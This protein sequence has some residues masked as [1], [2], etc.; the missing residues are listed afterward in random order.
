M[1]NGQSW[2]P[3]KFVRKNGQLRASRDPNEVQV[4][5]RLMT[6]VIARAYDTNLA[7]FARGRLLDLGCGKV[8]LFDAY[9]AL[10]SESVCVDWANSLHKNE[11]LDFECDL[12]KPLPFPDGEF[13][14]IILSDVLE[15]IP[16]PAGLWREMARVLRKDGCIIMNVPFLYWLH[17]QPH[18]YY[19]YTEFALRRFAEL[20]DMIVLKLE[21]MGGAPEVVADI[22]AKTLFKLPGLGKPAAITVQGVTYALLKTGLGQRV[23][24]ATRAQLPMGYFLVAQKQRVLAVN[25]T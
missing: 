21:A 18:D 14:T 1:K 17:E 23:S 25:G 19:R 4:S 12:T 15:H 7:A 5:S 24:R 8:P 20:S 3:S 10:V 6:D 2:K 13:D 11:Y 22:L 9:S 16:E